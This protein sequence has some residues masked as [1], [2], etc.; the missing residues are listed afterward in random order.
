[1]RRQGGFTYLGV[2]LAIA[3]LGIGLAAA[4]EVWSTTARR[5]RMAQLDW[6]G[7]QY[8]QAIGSYYESTPGR[9]KAYP[10]DLKDLV[11]DRRFAFVRRHLRQVYVNPLSGVADWQ[12]IN[13]ADGGIRGVRVAMIDAGNA[14]SGSREFA[15]VPG[16]R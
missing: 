8:V 16:V 1:M 2:L 12:L 3:L 7:Q 6:V 15:Y 5:Q 9:V 4:S 14:A 13:T 10:R 11:E